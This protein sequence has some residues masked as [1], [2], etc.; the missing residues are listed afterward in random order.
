MDTSLFRYIWRHSKRD[1]I[2]IL[3]IIMASLPFYFAML[4]LP[5]RI[6]NEAIQ[7]RA[8][9]G[10]NATTTFLSLGLSWPEWLGGGSVRFFEG[11]QVDRVGL[12]FGLSA[13]FLALVVANGGFKYFINVGKGALGERMLR[14]IRFDLF[15][16]ALRFTPQALREI[17][18][19]ETATIVKD[20]VEPI[21][22]FVGEAFINPVFLGTQA[23]TALLFILVQNVW[24]GLMA[25]GIIAVQFTV[26]PYLRRELLRL[27]KLRQIA[28]R[29]LAGRVGEVVEGMEA[30]RVHNASAWERAEIGHRLY[31]LFDL[32][33]RIYK[34]KFIV[35]FLNNFLAQITPFLFYSVGGYFALTGRLDIGQLVAAIGAYRELPPP[36][37]ELIDWDQQRLDVQIKYEQVLQHFSAD[38]LGPPDEG[39]AEAGEEKPL[40]G[41]LRIEDLRVADPAGSA[42][43]DGLTLACPLPARVALVSDGGPGA[44]T[45][46]R[47]LAARLLHYSGT[48]SVGDVELR[49]LS[50]SYLGRHIGYAGSDPV[51]FPGSLR[52]NLVYGLRHRPLGEPEEGPR[53]LARRIAEAKRTGNPVHSIRGKWIDLTLAGA[54][55]EDEL[56]AIL[57]GLLDQVGL[58]EDLYRF[59]LSGRLDPA[60]HGDLA[61]RLVEARSAVHER[62]AAGGMGDLVEHFDPQRYNAQATVGENLLFGVPTKP[63]LAGR[64]L[65]GHAAFRTAL[66]KDGLDRHLGDLGARI[67]ETMLEIFRGLPPG[68]P[69]F[70]QFS[71]IGADELG[72]FQAILRRHR[73]GAQFPA[74]DLTRLLGLTLAYVEPRHRLGL[75]G[76]DLQARLV[77]ARAR[78]RE[79]LSKRADPGVDFYVPGEVCLSAPIREN[80]LFGRSNHTAPDAQARLTAVITEVVD[81]LGLRPLVERLGLEFQVGPAGR[82]LTPAQRAAAALVRILVKRPDMLVVDGGVTALGEAQ[83]RHVLGLLLRLFEDRA[84]FVV[85]SNAHGADGFDGAIVFRGARASLEPDRT[86]LP[87]AILAEA[88]VEADGARLAETHA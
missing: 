20:E 70:D 9:E 19:T 42:V 52:E 7:G 88:E 82:Q 32:R 14:R 29:Q 28:S 33:F 60:R 71:L 39:A 46:A 2:V 64:E 76:P 67:A 13:V 30:V 83:G 47:I 87:R 85:V 4:D 38:R 58:G 80:L 57:I 65:A 31:E 5:R 61:G 41:P 79:V 40:A 50:R 53:D 11:I 18:A 21:G 75:I 62:L 68:H 26:I 69:L 86:A 49:T 77:E 34:R 36:L 78:V 72:D 56:D 66:H 37:K 63:S 44:T 84:L 45:L 54:G 8:F 55:D 6:V 27:G 25:A 22:G 1:Q 74:R 17:R 43:L 73:G 59:G 24:L 3:T 15:N 16:L 23:A 10:G 81:G 12:L 48:V 35:K 51:L